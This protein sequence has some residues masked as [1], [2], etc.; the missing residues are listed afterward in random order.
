MNKNILR[1][2]KTAGHVLANSVNDLALSLRCACL[3]NRTTRTAIRGIDPVQF[4]YF[5]NTSLIL[6]FALLHTA[7]G[8]VTYFG[9][10]FN[11]ATEVNPILI[12]FAGTMGLGLAIF[13]LKLL[14]VEFIA[15][16]YFARRNINGGWATV[17]LLSADAFYSWVVSNNI[18]LV[19]G[20]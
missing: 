19:V 17:S 6:L 3:Y 7:D 13:A 2:F 15:V 16:L 1:P 12:F 8:I 5:I 14:C 20:A 18:L 11:Y 10:K 9:L 4:K